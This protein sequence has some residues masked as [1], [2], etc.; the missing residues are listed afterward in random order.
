GPMIYVGGQVDLDSAG[1]VRHRDDLA[2]Q[3]DAVLDYIER[4]LSELGA[5][6]GDVVKLGAYYQ[7]TGRVDEDQFLRRIRRRIRTEP[8]PAITAIPLPR[9]AYPGMAGEIEA[10]A[11][12][13][14]DRSRL[15]RLA[16]QPRTH[17]AWPT[18][19]EFSHGLRCGDLIFLSGNMARD[20]RGTVPNPNDIVEQ[21][22]LTLENIRKVLAGF[23]AAMD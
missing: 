2:H 15:P 9:L 4:V 20:D 12:R 1:N 6:L 21:A 22:K 14:T 8:A 23:G 17:W 18:G 3:T 19:A 13:G 5:D 16:S 10:I 11:M 7:A